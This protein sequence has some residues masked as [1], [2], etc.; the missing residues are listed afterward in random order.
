VPTFTASAFARINV[1]GSRPNARPT[2]RNETLSAK[3]CFTRRS[4]QT[5]GFGFHAFRHAVA[6]LINAQTGNLKLAQKLAVEQ[7]ISADLFPT[8]NKTDHTAVN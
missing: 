2:V 7:A 5:Q 8:G 6:S 4:R 1:A 3:R